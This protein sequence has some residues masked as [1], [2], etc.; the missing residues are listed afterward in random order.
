MWI[1][2]IAGLFSCVGGSHLVHGTQQQHLATIGGIVLSLAAGSYV[3]RQE[4]MKSF[5]KKRS[6]MWFLFLFNVGVAIVIPFL[7]HGGAGIGAAVGM[8][9]VGLGAG[10]GLLTSR[11]NARV[12][13][14]A[15]TRQPQP[16]AP[17]AKFDRRPEHEF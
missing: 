2:F 4:P 14:H 10:A 5:L 13:A 12:P 6:V 15:R 16:A 8:G 7:V 1:L 11:K 17:R 3:A 9:L